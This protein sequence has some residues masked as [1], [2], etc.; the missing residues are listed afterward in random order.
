MVGVGTVTDFTKAFTNLAP[1]RG[2]AAPSNK[3]ISIVCISDY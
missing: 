3:R 2:T 1:T